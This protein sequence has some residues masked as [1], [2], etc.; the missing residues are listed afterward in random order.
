[1]LN[2]YLCVT[3]CTNLTLWA[4]SLLF[5]FS[6]CMNIFTISTCSFVIRKAIRRKEKLGKMENICI[7]FKRTT[8]CFGFRY[9]F[10]TC[11][12]RA[13]FLEPGELGWLGRL[14]GPVTLERA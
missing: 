2:L 9:C 8:K 13:G 12:R 4:I 11:V 10:C 3:D 14:R 7:N 5:C 6:V 1:M